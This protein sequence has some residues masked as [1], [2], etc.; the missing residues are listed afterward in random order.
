[1]NPEKVICVFSLSKADIFRDGIEFAIKW[2]REKGENPYYF[3]EKKPKNGL[4][5]GSIVLFSFE[6]QIFGQ[7]TVK[8]DIQEVPL[9]ERQRLKKEFGFDYKHYMILN[10]INPRID[11]FPQ[12]PKKKDVALK[13]GK[14]FAQLFTYINWEQYQQILEMA[15][16]RYI[17]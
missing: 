1:M 16:S 10:P 5:S 15:G 6:A 11:I 17:A 14:E 4:P 2:L 13:I 12:C 3:R 8:E 9:E 7:A